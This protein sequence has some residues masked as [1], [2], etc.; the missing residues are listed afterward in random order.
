MTR[1]HRNHRAERATRL[2]C[3]RSL[4][5]P[6]SRPA[7]ANQSASGCARR[8]ASAVWKACAAR[9]RPGDPWGP[10]PSRSSAASYSLSVSS[11]PKAWSE[12]GETHGP[13]DMKDWK[14]Q[15]PR[16]PACQ[17]CA[18]QHRAVGLT[19]AGRGHPAS[20]PQPSG[21]LNR[22]STFQ[23]CLC[24]HLSWLMTNRPRSNHHYPPAVALLA[25]DFGNTPSL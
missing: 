18:P 7:S 23:R 11:C 6:C 17:Y 13:Y 21:L 4:P 9:P 1:C 14:S 16:R 24:K 8:H 3:A 25:P 19:A 22:A 10:A 20:C 12:V 15:G 5:R 2:L